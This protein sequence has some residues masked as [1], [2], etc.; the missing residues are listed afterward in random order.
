[1]KFIVTKNNAKVPFWT[2]DNPVALQNEYDQAPFGN[3]GIAPKGIEIWIP[4]IPNLLPTVCD[5]TMYGI[6]PDVME[7]NDE[8]IVI[9]N[10]WLQIISSTSF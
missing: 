1:M 10:N 4:I 5:P 6:L 9:R 3:L 7:I 8:R 2:S